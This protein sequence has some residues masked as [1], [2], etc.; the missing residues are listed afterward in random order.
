MGPK[1]SLNPPASQKIYQQSMPAAKFYSKSDGSNSHLINLLA[2]SRKYKDTSVLSKKTWQRRW[3]L[4]LMRRPPAVSKAGCQEG[5]RRCELAA[6]RPDSILGCS[7]WRR[8]RRR[9]WRALSRWLT[10]AIASV[11]GR[12]RHRVPGN[13]SFSWSSLNEISPNFETK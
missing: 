1:K 2:P 3:L 8:Y 5:K 7:A 6:D 10:A 9:G 4:R 12:R 11:R 13:S